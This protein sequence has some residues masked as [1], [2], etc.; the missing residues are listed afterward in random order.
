MFKLKYQKAL[1]V[2]LLLIISA[3]IGA[4]DIRIDSLNAALQN[5]E[6]DT[7]RVNILNEL[8]D[9]L[10]PSDPEQAIRYGIDAKVLAENS[11]YRKGLA[12]AYKNI[13]L[14]HYML[15]N[16]TEALENWDPSLAL[17]ME[18]GDDKLVANLLSNR[19]SVFYTTGNN[20]QAIENYLRAL[21]IA[22]QLNDSL[23]IGTLFLNIGLVYLEQPATLDQARDYCIRSVAL[24]ESIGNTRLVGVGYLNLGQ[25]YMRKEVY[26]SALYYY[27]KTLHVLSSSMN[28]STVYNDIGTIYAHKKD[29]PTALKYQFDALDLA[30]S[31]SAQ[32]QETSVLLGLASTYEQQ[33]NLN[34]ALEYYQQ[35]RKLAEEIGIESELSSAYKG[36]ADIYAAL[37]D[38]KRAFKYINLHIELD[39]AT[40][41]K[42]TE[43]KTNT[44]MFSYQLDKKQNEIA[45]LEQQSEIEQL[46]SK[47]QKAILFSI[48]GVG[49]LLLV[50]A[51]GLYNRMR[52]IRKTNQM[53]K[54][55]KDEIESQRD[56]IEAARDQIQKQHDMVYSQKEMITD[57][58]SYAERIQSALLP[59]KS[60][61][62]EMMDEY[63]VILKPKDIVSG[64]FYWV[65]EVQDHLVIVGAD[66][67]GHGVPGAFMSMLGMTLLNGLINDRCFDAPS[68]ILESLRHKIKVMLDQDGK[69]D[70]QKDGMD[71]A[72]AILN[73]KNR[74]LHFA[75]A[76]NPLYII[77]NKE[78][79]VGKE[80]EPFASTENGHF[81][82]FEIK[83]DKQ[84]VG[85]HWEETPF[86]THSIHLQEQDSIYLFSDGFIDQ[87]GGEKR[88]KFMSGNFKKLLLSVQN[89]TMDKQGQIL[90]ETF[91]SWRGEVEQ[92]DDVSVI[93]VKI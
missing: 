43:N 7:L 5:A 22:E 69:T 63:F 45:L 48:G 61:L 29:Y 47:R 71:L 75:G 79:G 64:D 73:K 23:R 19:G 92:I 31:E 36:M 14:G 42:E 72:L 46:R 70:E 56:E 52:F 66:C 33:G 27:D 68:A 81:L 24:G 28:I 62:D 3:Y 34:K 39:N 40:L 37:S 60:V 16:F 88:K 84:P 82:L 1:Q 57:S 87:F 59:S 76:N 20:V 77:R 17:Y 26:D 83:G 18:L 21:K 65:K 41:Q 85:T 8:A 50:L 54:A 78:L 89:E 49:L 67:T 10:Y 32:Y 38:Y 11:N 80:L 93:G 86:T 6:E 44:L 35:A 9:H 4:Q 2:L 74:E 91:E 51:G 90:E 25:I 12:F 15:G 13:G 55:Q 53:I 30:R 58:I